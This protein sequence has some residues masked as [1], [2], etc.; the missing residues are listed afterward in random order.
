MATAEPQSVEELRRR[1][2]VEREELAAA[3]DSL[4]DELGFEAKLRAKLP[5]ALVGASGAGFVLAGGVGATFRLI[6]RRGRER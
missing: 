1:I 4:R 2:G 5:L 6:F 3:V